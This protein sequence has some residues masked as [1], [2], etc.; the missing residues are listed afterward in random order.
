M[1]ISTDAILAYGYDLGEWESM[2]Y[3]EWFDE[4]DEDAAFSEQAMKHLLKEAGFTETDWKVEGYWNRKNEAEKNLGIEITYYCSYDYP[5]Y[6]L[7]AKE[8]RAYRGDAVKIDYAD[9]TIDSEWN[10][11]LRW[12]LDK[13]GVPASDDEPSWFLVSMWG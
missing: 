10:E 13:L 3:P 1:G 8:F 11:K 2:D 4:D 5:M 6:I 7:S 12:A 9:L